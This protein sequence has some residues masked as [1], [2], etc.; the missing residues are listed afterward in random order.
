M[1]KIL[2][3]LAM[4]LLAVPAFAQH[5]GTGPTAGGGGG[6][7]IEDEDT[8]VTVRDTLNFAGAG[9][10]CA[11]DTTQTTCTVAGGASA[12]GEITG[13]VSDQTDL[14]TEVNTKMEEPAGNGIAVRTGDDTSI[15]RT[16][17][18]SDGSNTVSNG[19][20]T[21]GN[22]DI[23]VDTAVFPR[24]SSGTGAAPATGAVGTFYFKTDTNDPYTYPSTD[25]ETLLLTPANTAI[26]TNKTIDANGTGNVITTSKTTLRAGADAIS[27]DTYDGIVLSGW[28]CGASIAQWDAVYLDDTAN[29]WLIADADLPGAFPARGVATAACTDGNPGIIL[30]QGVV[31]N[32]A[33]EW[34]ANGST[35]FLSDT[36]T[37]SSWTVTAPST[38]GDAV[39]VIG[40]AINDDQVYFNFS[41]HYLEV[42]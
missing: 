14:Q 31:R 8:P 24:Y 28:N 23:V 21:G 5:G 4:L 36:G 27:D 10:T 32:D 41:G 15:N 37:G 20:G 40:F 7:V 12:W 17:T 33:W 22:I 2:I 35:L 38:S 13:T 25:T 11:D 26:L 29:E 39:Q 34:A 42:E 3:T 1:R 9:V 18:S 30:V 16:V 19:D 6:H